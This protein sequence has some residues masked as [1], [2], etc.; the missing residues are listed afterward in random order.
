MEFSR[1]V[2]WSRLPFLLQGIFPTH[3]WNLCFLHLLFWPA[4]SLPL[5]PP[6]KHKNLQRRSNSISQSYIL[7]YKLF[8]TMLAC[9]WDRSEG[10]QNSI[11]VV[12]NKIQDILFF[13]LNASTYLRITT[14]FP[15]SL[16]WVSVPSVSLHMVWFPDLS[17]PECHPLNQLQWIN[18]FKMWCPELD[19]VLQVPCG[20]HPVP[21]TTQF[22]SQSPLSCCTQSQLS[23]S[24]AGIKPCHPQ[25]VLILN[26]KFIFVYIEHF[27]LMLPVL[28]VSWSCHLCT[29]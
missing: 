24:R 15:F 8:W 22:F 9:L 28:A 21:Q 5:A 7:S 29:C 13:Y 12:W 11:S 27:F 23:S 1:Q 4:D 10:E 19:M 17:C 20:S 25:P 14:V 2:Y 6:R 16:L 3:G 26:V 18:V